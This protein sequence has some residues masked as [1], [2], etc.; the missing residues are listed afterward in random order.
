MNEFK[1]SISI[2]LIGK[3]KPDNFLPEKLADA[4]VVSKKI[5]ETASY[6]TLIPNQTI[7]LKFAWA[8]LMVLQDRFQITSLVA[9]HIRICDFAQK[10]LI[11]L[12]PDSTVSQFGINVTNHYDFGSIEAKNNFG[13]KLSPFD[14]WGTWGQ[15]ITGS[16]EDNRKGTT[17]QG[18]LTGIQIRLPFS[19]NMSNGW[20]AIIAAPSIE[21]PNNTGVLLQ[22]N[23]HHQISALS[24]GDDLT[25]K[26]IPAT[27]HTT[28]LLDLLSS[29]FE[30]SIQESIS[31]FQAGLTS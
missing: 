31:I 21:V 13:K 16:F 10:A 28:M 1:S 29:N 12:A 11:D 24:V 4:G 3:F 23:H 6:I 18:G 15:E 5:A 8:E 20:R 19:N 30:A 9:P 14:I 26:H 22:A 27:E 17:L 25:D 2:V 7:H